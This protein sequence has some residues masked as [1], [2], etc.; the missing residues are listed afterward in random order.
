M[1]CQNIE[2][3]SLSHTMQEDA[4][5]EQIVLWQELCSPCCPHWGHKLPHVFKVHNLLP[6]LMVMNL[7]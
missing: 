1:Y 3:Q 7:N 4:I 5:E 2:L 6:F